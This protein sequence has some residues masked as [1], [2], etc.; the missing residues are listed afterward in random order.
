MQP[1]EHRRGFSFGLFFIRVA[2]AAVILAAFWLLL[3]Y[4]YSPESYS[5]YP[6]TPYTVEFVWFGIALVTTIV[7]LVLVL[8]PR[9]QRSALAR[10]SV[11]AALVSLLI[12]S[13]HLMG[14]PVRCYDMILF[15]VAIGWGTALWTRSVPGLLAG[16]NEGQALRIKVFGAVVWTGAVVLGLY[17][18]WQQVRYWNDL[19]LGYDDCGS[20]ASILYNTVSNPRELFLAMNPNQRACWDHFNPGILAFVPLWILWPDVRL[21][22]ALQVVVV[23]GVAVPLYLIGRHLF[24]DPIAALLLAVSWLVYPSVSQL[25][26]NV[27]YGFHWGNV[28]LPLYFVAL[29]L[30]MKGRNGWALA[31]VVWAFLMKEEAA[32]VVGMFGLYLAIFKRRRGLGVAMAATAFAYFL[33]VITLLIPAL[34]T[35]HYVPIRFFSNLG[36]SLPGNP[37]VAG[38]PAAPLLGKPARIALLVL[39]GHAHGAAALHSVEETLDPSHRFVDLCLCLHA[40]DDEE[41]QPALSGRPFARGF[42]GAGRGSQ[43]QADSSA[44]GGARGRDCF[45]NDA[46]PVPR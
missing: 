34:K 4:R 7:A 41:H 19:A 17:F 25:I 8:P 27:S 37:A 6:I 16:R 20:Q 24:E 9:E 40:P 26:Y 43:G 11:P 15:C 23:L 28:C 31:A 2:M 30:W 44:P 29:L 18:F 46:F 12:V 10:S 38:G 39:R 42:L 14:M 33:V 13:K 1:G 3:G 35:G 36:L 22:F 45:G 32:I 21:M 5:T